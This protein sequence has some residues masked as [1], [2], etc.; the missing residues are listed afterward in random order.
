[1]ACGGPPSPA[2]PPLPPAAEAESLQAHLPALH[3]ASLPLRFCLR[4]C[5]T[6]PLKPSSHPS[7]GHK[8]RP[9]CAKPL[10][11]GSAGVS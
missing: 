8:H 2:P 9:A 1:M 6:S 5:S 10:Q 4:S 3:A 7:R 11:A